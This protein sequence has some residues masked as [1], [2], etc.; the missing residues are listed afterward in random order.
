MIQARSGNDL[1][2]RLADGEDLVASLVGLDMGS[3]VVIGA[4]GMVRSARLAYWNG[5][6]YETFEVPGPVELLSMQGNLGYEGDTPVLHCH[7]AVASRRG[8]TQGGH[9]VAAV[10]HNTVEI[11]CRRLPGIVLE[12]RSEPSGTAALHPR[13]IAR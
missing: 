11:V 5:A 3:A 13:V 9:L 10:A 4:I 2:L 6:E 12:R 7:V 8:V 1:V